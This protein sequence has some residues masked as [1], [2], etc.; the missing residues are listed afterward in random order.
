MVEADDSIATAAEKIFTL[1]QQDDRKTSHVKLTETSTQV[2]LRPTSSRI[3]PVD[4]TPHDRPADGKRAEGPLHDHHDASTK[5]KISQ[6]VRKPDRPS[7]SRKCPPEQTQPVSQPRFTTRNQIQ[8]L[9]LSSWTDILIFAIPIGIVLR[10]TDADRRA[11]FA[12]N[13]LALLQLGRMQSYTVEET[14]L[15]CGEVMGGLLNASFG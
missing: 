11:V 8:K 1:W 6:E 13:F 9:F 10:Y 12:L 7:A 14:A 5:T 4:D 15:R 2:S 3:E